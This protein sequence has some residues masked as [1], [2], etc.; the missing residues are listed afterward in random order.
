M[1]KPNGSL[2]R[3]ILDTSAFLTLIE[4]EDGADV[5]QNLLQRAK[6]DNLKI[7]ASFVSFT[8]VL[9]ITLQERD[10]EEAQIRLDLMKKL[11]I[12][13]VESSEDIGRLAGELKAQHRISFADAWIAATAQF[14]N[15]TLVH[16]DPEFEQ[17][18]T[19][20]TLLPLP[21]K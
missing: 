9:Y 17:I 10:D 14:Y 19:G 1:K 16:K 18:Q 12:E 5:V 6:Q 8:E 21:Y 2:N 20:I 15:A 11:P 3:Y 7:F 4:D 13:R